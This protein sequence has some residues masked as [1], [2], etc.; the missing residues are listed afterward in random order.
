MGG[1]G[2]ITLG[3][4]STYR[5]MMPCSVLLL[6]TTALMH[7]KKCQHM[8]TRVRPHTH[9]QMSD[10]KAAEERV[11]AWQ[12]AGLLSQSAPRLEPQSCADGSKQK[13][14]QLAAYQLH[15]DWYRVHPHTHVYDLVATRRQV[16]V[17]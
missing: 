14:Q 11:N 8:H 10:A 5:V 7:V 15:R 9:V 2:S 3:H 13:Q 16:Y 1:R 12:R 6:S 4:S 17:A